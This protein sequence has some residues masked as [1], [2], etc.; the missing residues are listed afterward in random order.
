M[1]A[2]NQQLNTD[3]DGVKTTAAYSEAQKQWAALIAALGDIGIVLT[4]TTLAASGEYAQTAVDALAPTGI[5]KPSFPV[6]RVRGL[7]HASH[8]GTLYVEESE[9]GSS[10]TAAKT[11]SVSANT[12]TDSG[13]V[14]IVKRY[15]RFRYVNGATPQTSFIL[16]QQADNLTSGA[17]SSVDGAHVTIGATTDAEAATGNGSIIAVLKNLRTRIGNL[18]TYLDTVESLLTSIGNNTDTL[19]SG[20]GVPSDAEAV[21]GDGSQVAILKNLRTRLGNIETYTDQ[22][23]AKLDI[24]IAQT[25]GLEAGVGA[26]ADAEAP[27]GNGSQ[28]AILKNLRTRIGNLEA[29]LDS[30]EAKLDTLISQTDNLETF[31][32]GLEGILL[33]SAARTATINSPDVVN[34]RRNGIHVV[35]DVT[36]IDTAP[37]ITLKIEGKDPAS[38][39]YYTILEGAAVTAV[40]TNVYKVF[41][42]A[43][44]AANAVANDIIPKTW[45][46]TVTHAN[47]NPITYSVG[48]SLV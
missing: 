10:W 35:L 47:A 15:Y 21:S 1:P 18:E 14:T 9:N 13:W 4:T 6:G 12:T 31:L 17:T 7:A 39:K 32:E 11:V 33:A 29:Y 8:A 45:R 20:N 40:S 41:S 38:G 23:E 2:F 44:A 28:I 3:L 16:V 26:Q 42:A 19:E 25:D 37:S 36:A 27:S 48:Y 46:V 34:G 5:T 22:L 30:V 24:L 43:T